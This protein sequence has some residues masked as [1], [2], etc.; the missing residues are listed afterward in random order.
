MRCIASSMGEFVIC[1]V[2]EYTMWMVE[3]LYEMIWFMWTELIVN[4]ITVYQ[5]SSVFDGSLIT[6]CD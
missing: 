6:Q 4:C 1:F 2:S 5:N 3:L